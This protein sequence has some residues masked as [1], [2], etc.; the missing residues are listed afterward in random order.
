VSKASFKQVHCLCRSV[1]LLRMLPSA[2]KHPGHDNFRAF[3]TSTLD[4]VMVQPYSLSA[5]LHVHIV[6]HGRENGPQRVLRKGYPK[7]AFVV[8]R[9]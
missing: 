6:P 2:C 3:C 4:A 5:F 1:A 7:Q 8:A 9:N